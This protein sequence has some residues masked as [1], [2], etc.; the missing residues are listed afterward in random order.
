M[1]A[2]VMSSDSDIPK[3]RKVD[4]FEHG[5]GRPFNHYLKCVFIKKE[6]RNRYAKNIK[7]FN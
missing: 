5:E 3:F 7:I 4:T 6:I 2:Q 1:L